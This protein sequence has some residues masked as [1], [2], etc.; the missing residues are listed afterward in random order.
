MR[1]KFPAIFL[2]FL[3][4]LVLGWGVARAADQQVAGGLKIV[5]SDGSLLQGAVS[6]VIN[7]DTQYGQIKIPSSSMI[8]A[9][10]DQ[11]K[12]WADIRLNGAELKM[13]YKPASSDLNA[14]LAMGPLNISLTKVLSIDNGSAEAS[15]GTAPQPS[16]PPPA[17]VSA[18]QP[19][20]QTVSP[21]AVAYQY[22]YQ[23][24][25]AQPAPD[26]S[27]DYAPYY[28]LGSYPYYYPYYSGYPYYYGYGWPYIG[29]GFGWGGFYG[30]FGRGFGG[31]HG[32]FHGGFG[33][34]HGGF[35][36]GHGGGGHR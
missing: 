25:Y 8:S 6:F 16:A 30:G 23:Y 3:V 27:Y 32:G 31:F 22:P 20:P 28:G 26:Y 7:L 11:Q 14:T 18:P 29:L 34:F 33:G 9:R 15:S 1:N 5:L 10:F 24:Q 19:P 17:M 21:P 2:V 4:S 36:G 13:K 35:G 12:E